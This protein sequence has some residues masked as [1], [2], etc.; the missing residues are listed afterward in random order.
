MAINVPKAVLDGI[1]AVRDS[2]DTNMLA[3]DEV[4]RLCSKMGFHEAAFWVTSH[5]SEYSHGVF[6]G[7]QVAE[8]ATTAHAGDA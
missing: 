2:G 1:T 5:K 4:A 3:R 8:E 6:Q 7:F